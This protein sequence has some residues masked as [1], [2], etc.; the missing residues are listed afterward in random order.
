M[1]RAGYV[2]AEP[3]AGTAGSGP[4]AG[5]G[6]AERPA[7]LGAHLRVRCAPPAPPGLAGDPDGSAARGRWESPC[8]GPCVCGLPPSPRARTGSPGPRRE[9]R[10]QGHPAAAAADGPGRTEA[11]RDPAAAVC[12]GLWRPRVRAQ[13]GRERLRP[14]FADTCLLTC[15]CHLRVTCPLCL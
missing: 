12:P 14:G 7:R 3:L 5:T 2:S 13:A 10:A 1:S 15:A 9:R 11:L 4:R 8:A 6:Q